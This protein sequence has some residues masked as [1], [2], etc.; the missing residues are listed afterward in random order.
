[1]AHPTGRCQL[2]IGPMF[3]GKTT[4]ALRRLGTLV[5][6]GYEC[7]FVNHRDHQRVTAARDEYVSTHHSQYKGMSPKIHRILASRLSEVDVD[8]FDAI[9]VDEGQFFDDLDETVR[10]WVFQK[11]KMVI[12][13][14]LDGD[15]DLRP[16]G[17]V[18]NLLSICEQGNVTKLTAFCIPCL[19]Q[20]RLVNASFTSR[21][22]PGPAQ[23][24]PGGADK[25]IPVC[26]KCYQK[27]N[28]PEP[29][30]RLDQIEAMNAKMLNSAP[31][32]LMVARK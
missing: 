9:G 13:A 21:I 11:K 6:V 20:K 8:D 28:A 10:T 22:N 4:E 17:K 1:M 30:I 26:M 27:Q 12:V 23:K 15:S 25:Y 24:D 18:H 14:S 32:E 3:A 2:I 5:D 31:D 7:G 19:K 16:F 29:V